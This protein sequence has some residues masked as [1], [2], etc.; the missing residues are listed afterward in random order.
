MGKHLGHYETIEPQILGE[1]QF[2]PQLKP[3]E[4]LLIFPLKS[5]REIV[6]LL[7]KSVDEPSGSQE[8]KSVQNKTTTHISESEYMLYTCIM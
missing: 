1:L 8:S 5:A 3:C 2:V 4:P 6:Q 7:K